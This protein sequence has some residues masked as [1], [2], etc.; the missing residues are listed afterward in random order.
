MTIFRKIYPNQCLFNL[1]L[2]CSE[3]TIATMWYCKN[4]VI[5]VENICKRFRYHSF[6]GIFSMLSSN[7][8]SSPNQAEHFTPRRD[9]TG[10]RMLKLSVYI[11]SFTIDVV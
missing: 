10:E 6:E 2:R 7:S 3:D 4:L 8:V 5:G 11:H 9:I 1:V